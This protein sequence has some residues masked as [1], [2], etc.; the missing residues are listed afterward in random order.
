MAVRCNDAILIWNN[1]IF[2]GNNIHLLLCYVTS[3]QTFPLSG[4]N[5]PPE[6]TPQH[7]V[8]KHSNTRVRSFSAERR[9]SSIT[10]C[11]NTADTWHASLFSPADNLSTPHDTLSTRRFTKRV[12]HETVGARYHP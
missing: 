6:P 8:A 2:T 1:I 7:T 9:R 3:V 4:R 11:R 10:G 12:L 5:R